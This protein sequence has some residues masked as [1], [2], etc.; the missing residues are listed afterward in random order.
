[1]LASIYPLNSMLYVKNFGLCDYVCQ[2]SADPV[3]YIIV[4]LQANAHKYF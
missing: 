3:T 1:M 4:K 2:V